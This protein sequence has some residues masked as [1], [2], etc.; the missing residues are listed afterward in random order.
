M[1]L[2]KDLLY[3]IEAAPRGKAVGAFFDFD[4]TLIAGFSATAFL[5]EHIRRGDVSP[6]EFLEMLSAAT[7]FSVGGLGFSASASAQDVSCSD[8]IWSE[9]ALEL[10]PNIGELCLE[11]VEKRGQ[12]MAR[13]RARVVRQSVNATIVQWQRPDEGD[14]TRQPRL[15]PPRPARRRARSGPAGARRRPGTRRRR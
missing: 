2:H 10:N 8:I 4:G 7:Q 14:R 11:V 15:R 3:N 12:Q 9:T 6:Y 13:M 1:S 5:K